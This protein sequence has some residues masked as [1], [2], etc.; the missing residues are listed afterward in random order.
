M[1]CTERRNRVVASAHLS[2]SLVS[3]TNCRLSAEWY[4]CD[5]ALQVRFCLITDQPIY[6]KSIHL[7]HLHWNSDGWDRTPQLTSLAQLLLDGYF[8]T[9][10]GFIVLIEKEWLSFG[11][12]KQF[13]LAL[14]VMLTAFRC[15]LIG[16]KF[17]ERIGHGDSNYRDKQRSPIFF[18]WFHHS[19]LLCYCNLPTLSKHVCVYVYVL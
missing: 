10:P 13:C 4:I 7:W 17:S 18:Q 12:R 6:C 5:C 15:L 1:D 9:I 3:H 2:S 19:V 16:H 11:T 8:R 14:T